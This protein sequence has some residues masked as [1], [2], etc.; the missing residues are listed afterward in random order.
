MRTKKYSKIKIRRVNTRRVNTRRVNTRNKRFKT[1][2]YKGG[3]DLN[4][5]SD[6]IDKHSGD[7]HSGDKHSGDKHSGDKHSNEPKI[8]TKTREH[9]EYSEKSNREKH[10]LKLKLT[11]EQLAAYKLAKNKKPT[12]DENKKP[13]HEE[14]KKLSANVVIQPL[15]GGKVLD[16][17]G[18]GCVFKPS[19]KCKGK[20]RI[21]GYISKLMTIDNTD[22]EFIEIY[23]YVPILKKI[24][25]YKNYFVIDNISMCDPDALTKEDLDDFDKC[26]ALKRYNITPQNINSKLNEFAM[27]NEPDGGLELDEYIKLHFTNYNKMIALNNSLINLLKHG[28]IPMNRLKIYHIDIKGSNILVDESNP[29]NVLTRLIDWGLSEQLTTYRDALDKLSLHPYQFNL[30]YSIIIFYHKFNTVYKKFISVKIRTYDEIYSFVSNYLVELIQSPKGGH[31]RSTLKHLKLI[32]KIQNP[33]SIIIK[34]VTE[35]LMKY[36]E[37]NKLN[38]YKYL[39]IFLHN[40]DIWGF[41]ISYE[42]IINTINTKQYINNTEQNMINCFKKIFMFL[43]QHNLSPINV[44]KLISL[45]QEL[46]PLFKPDLSE[47][48]NLN[49][50]VNDTTK[51]SDRS[52]LT[53]ELKVVARGIRK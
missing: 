27:L 23:K 6:P 3:T 18:F 19:L 34:Y 30:P 50:F 51:Q 45:L 12:H 31:L 13:T 14:L 26:A 7:K 1:I 22:D 47:R 9:S 49:L 32:F 39:P 52:K 42:S 43:F 16:S 10:K 53:D 48:K 37:K 40:V 28:I 25:N 11:P 4:K 2:K 24:P 29:T 36:T 5:M 41:V 44:P 35:I 21:P 46:N 38:I 8:N 33:I 17:G 20:N 15:H